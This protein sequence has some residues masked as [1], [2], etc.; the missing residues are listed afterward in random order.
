LTPAPQSESTPATAPVLL[1]ISRLIWRARRAG[2]SGIDRVELAYAQHFLA[3]DARRPAYAVVHVLGRLFALSP[4]GA[5]RFVRKLAARWQGNPAGGRQG[6]IGRLLELYASLLTG[7]WRLGLELRRQ[8]RRHPAPPVFVVV[9][10]H[11][12]S[13]EHTLRAIR[14][15]FGVRCVCLLHDLIPIDYP[16]YVQAGKAQRHRRL[17][18]TIIR[19]FE[20]VIVNSATTAES[21]RHFLSSDC[22]QR[23]TRTG[24]H[25][26]LP[27]A[28]AFP[29]PES[30]LQ[31]SPA[32]GSVPYFV[33]LG[34]I[35]PK[36]NHL[37]LLNLWS[38]L[39]TT[40]ATPPRLL[41]IGARGWENEQILDMLERSRRLRGL[42]EE[43]NR[44]DD[45]AIG[46]H[47]RG[48]RALL[49]PSFVEGFG[50][51]LAEALASGVPV[52]CSDIPV[53]REVGRDVPDYADPLDLLAWRDAIVDYS[54]PDSA[55][56]AAQMRRLAHWQ[57][58]S[59]PDHF[60]IV[61]S[62][63][64]QIALAPRITP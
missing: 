14:R 45:A 53:F 62:A 60:Q 10:H 57:P 47:L 15:A 24:V 35:E 39:A 49:V 32:P 23:L 18:E 26:A 8:L 25:I 50:L 7:R 61:E 28:R 38:R 40:L 37:L 19:C 51:P 46:S 20:A 5:R 16:E 64:D 27:G 13:R 56:R 3:A 12:L 63:L 54:A 52:I 44:L 36:K 48:A 2:P 11:H 33:V 31:L 1:D 17:I 59:W 6:A 30:R 55:R 9:S 22:E 4:S 41:V 42:V 21:F 34:T 58:P 29:S 43:H